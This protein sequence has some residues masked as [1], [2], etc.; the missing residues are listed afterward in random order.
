[1]MEDSVI[2]PFHSI[3]SSTRQLLT[4]CHST[5]ISCSA[6][7]TLHSSEGTA[8]HLPSCIRT[9]LSPPSSLNH[10]FRT[11]VREQMEFRTVGKMRSTLTRLHPGQTKDRTMVGSGR[12]PSRQ[13][14]IRRHLACLTLKIRWRRMIF[15]NPRI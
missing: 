8:C 2:P 12:W 4:V 6:W 9:N 5:V 14:V 15:S 11:L 3:R 13:Q 10:Q 1:M 7:G